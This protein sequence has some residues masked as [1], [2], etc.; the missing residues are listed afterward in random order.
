LCEFKGRGG[1]AK[2]KDEL[3]TD[4]NF[5]G[6]RLARNYKLRRRKQTKNYS[7]KLWNSKWRERN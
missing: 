3:K 5:I 1:G 2:I 6:Q 4:I 7:E